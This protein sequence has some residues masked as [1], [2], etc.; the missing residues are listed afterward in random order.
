[1]LRFL[2]NLL[3][4]GGAKGQLSILIYHRVLAAPDPLL[5]DVVDAEVFERHVKMLSEDFNVLPLA[6]GCERLSGG[7]LP[8]RAASITFDDGYADNERIA[9]PILKRYHLTATFFIATAFSGN[10]IM[11]NDV[12][13]ESVRAAQEGTHDLSPLGLGLHTLNDSVT[14]RATVDALLAQ[15]KYRPP[16]ERLT[17]VKQ[18]SEQFNCELPTDLMMTESQI[19]RLHDAGM[20]IGAHTVNHPIL[21]SLDEKDAYREIVN[22]KDHLEEIIAAPI[23]LFAYPNGKPGVDYAP[24]DVE[25]VKKAGFKA[26]VSTTSGTASRTSD[27][28][29]LP[30]FGPW[31]K[32]PTRLGARLLLNRLQSIPS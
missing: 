1:M 24:R 27:A 5:Y 23:S 2:G 18:I 3:A 30:R 4:P 26:A 11:F 22:G 31:D 17:L 21:S 8:P 6:E 29:Q 13:I 25:L 10:G 16:I 15:L 14:R 28:F 19:K 7:T 9:L 32:S 20:G 12:V